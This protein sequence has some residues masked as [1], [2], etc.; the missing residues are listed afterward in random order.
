MQL[1]KNKHY[2]DNNISF[3]FKLSTTT[4]PFERRSFILKSTLLELLGN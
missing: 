3:Y 2:W 1:K 4:P